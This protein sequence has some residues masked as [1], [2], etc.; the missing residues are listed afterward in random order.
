MTWPPS[1]PEAPDRR[2]VRD[3][4]GRYWAYPTFF[5]SLTALVRA[6]GWMIRDEGARSWAVTLAIVLP[7]GFALSYWHFRWTGDLPGEPWTRRRDED[8]RGRD[9]AYAAATYAEREARSHLV[10]RGTFRWASASEESQSLGLGVAPRLFASAR[11][12]TGEPSKDTRVVVDRIVPGQ[13]ESEV[14]AHWLLPDHV[15]FTI[16]PE[17]DLTLRNGRRV[18]AHLRVREVEPVHRS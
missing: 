4:A 13:L 17:T 3:W 15:G 7:T 6:S 5:L 2:R 18:I 10:M 9:I 8:E 12:R 16:K 14:E 11:A 1:A